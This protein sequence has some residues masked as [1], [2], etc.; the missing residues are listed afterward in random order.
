MKFLHYKLGFLAAGNIVVVTLDAR[1]N[2]QLLDAAN[3]S[4]TRRE[5]RTSITEARRRL[6]LCACVSRGPDTGMSSSIWAG[7]QA[8]CARVFKLPREIDGIAL[9]TNRLPGQT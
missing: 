4:V 1:A 9:R 2:V 5:G 8:L 6:R 7:I 3:F